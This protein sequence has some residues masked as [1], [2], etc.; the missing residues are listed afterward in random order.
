[1]FSKSRNR[2][3]CK[4]LTL[5]A[6]RSSHRSARPDWLRNDPC[7]MISPA[8]TLSL[9]AELHLGQVLVP[10]NSI[11]NDSAPGR[12]V[13]LQ[14]GAEGQVVSHISEGLLHDGVPERQSP[15]AR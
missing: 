13:V 8:S 1:M 10:C 3:S 4:R 2:A 15:R 6:V 9:S 11:S 14:I 7:P 12:L 5:S